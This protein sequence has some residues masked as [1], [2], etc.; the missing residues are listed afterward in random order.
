MQV[1]CHADR[2]IRE[3]PMMTQDAVTRHVRQI[4]YL[5]QWFVAIALLQLATLGWLTYKLVG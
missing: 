3:E 5:L 1:R 4:H 2:R